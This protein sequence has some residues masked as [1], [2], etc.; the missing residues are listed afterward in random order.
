M[1][2]PSRVPLRHTAFKTAVCAATLT[3]L[4]AIATTVRAQTDNF[5]S[6]A[7][8]PAAG[9]ATFNNP[10]YPANYSF[11]TDAFGGKAFRMQGGVPLNAGGDEGIGTSR[12]AALCTNQVYTDFYVA[13]DFVGW[14]TNP[15]HQTNYTFVGLAA[16]VT[17]DLAGIQTGTNWSGVALFYW[18]NVETQNNPDGPGTGVLGLGYVINGNMNFTIPSFTAAIGGVAPAGVAEW[19]L[20]PGHTY[21]VTFQGVGKNLYGAVYD[22]QDL[23]TP[24]GTVYGDTSL[25]NYMLGNIP[26]A[27]PAPTSGWSGLCALRFN[28]DHNTNGVTDATFDNFYAAV[29]P[30]TSVSAPAT[31]NGEANVAQ[32][33]SRTPASWANFYSPAG[34]ITFTGS[35]LSVS[36]TIN[37]SGTRL[38]LNGVDVSSS[39]TATTVSANTVYNTFGLAGST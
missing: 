19:T 25:S 31:P 28:R 8:N 3:A 39:L 11:P 32:V 6:G 26:V 7:L 1:T 20:E 33:I 10:I 38:I 4:L 13:A 34:G 36:T 37:P 22:T 35:T 29:T 21:R 14:D 30:P 27:P 15:Y 2:N 9:W 16:R 12:V 5:D 17:P 18:V 24:R 23:T